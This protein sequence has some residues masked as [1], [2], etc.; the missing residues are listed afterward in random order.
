MFAPAIATVQ[1]GKTFV[2]SQQYGDH[3]TISNCFYTTPPR[4][5][6]G[7]A[8]H[9]ITGN[10][11][12][13]VAMAGEPTEYNMS[14][15][16]AYSGSAG[17]KYNDIIYGGNIMAKGGD[18]PGGAGIGGGRYNSWGTLNIYGGSINATSG[19]E[20]V[21]IG[22][23][24][25]FIDDPRTR[26]KVTINGGTVIAHGDSYAAGIGGGDGIYG[27]DITINGGHVEAY[28]GVDG[29]GIGGGEDAPSGPV[30]INGGYVYAVGDGNAAGIGGGEDGGFLDIIITGG[31]VQAKG[32]GIGSGI[33]SGG[34]GG[35]DD[36]IIEISGDAI[37]EA[38][39][40]EDAAEEEGR[41]FGTD[42]DD[43]PY[44]REDFDDDFPGLPHRARRRL[45]GGGSKGT[46]MF[47]DHAVCVFAGKD[48]N[49]ATI[50][51]EDQRLLACWFNAYA[52]LEP[53]KHEGHTY[54][55]SGTTAK[56]THSMKCKY[57]RYAPT[58]L[59]NFEDKV[60]TVCG[61]EQT[62]SGETGIEAM[63]DGTGKMSG[64]WYDLQGRKLSSKPATKGVFIN[65]GRKTIIE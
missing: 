17:L 22:C 6:Q 61:V 51:N 32:S 4:D 54:T 45:W 53:C 35:D 14:G 40:G 41:A 5:V 34:A 64:D 37:V 33:S 25:Y 12:V 8:P 38:W 1:R 58:E 13:T 26:A 7:K 46:I 11:G 47:R 31:H 59:H 63:S 36:T 52:R 23:G 44:K 9:T 65:N 48:K 43:Q 62:F 2:R 10:E 39:A 60:C 42:S 49:S 20:A 19:H 15:I 3:V 21:G 55:Y 56:D 57:C 24:Q 18:S 16:T 27:A 50:I 30:T 28:G 29:A